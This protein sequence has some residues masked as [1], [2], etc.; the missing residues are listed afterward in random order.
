[1]I[2]DIQSQIFQKFTSGESVLSISKQLNLPY[3]KVDLLLVENGYKKINHCKIGNEKVDRVIS[4]INQKDSITEIAN[5]TNLDTST[6]FYIA[7]ENNLMIEKM[8]P[9]RSPSNWG[10]NDNYFEDINSEEKAYFVGL[11]YA[12]GAVRIHDG[13]YYLSLELTREDAYM[14][15]SLANELNCNNKIAIRNRVTPFGYNSFARFESCNSKKLLDDLSL[16]G[17]IPNKSHNSES[18][19]NIRERIPKHLIRHFLRGLIDGDGS[20][21]KRYQCNNQ[22]SIVIYQNSKKFC[23]D[24]DSLLKFSIGDCSIKES[25]MMNNETGM[26][27][28]RYRRI[29]DVQKIAEHLYKNSKMHLKRKYELAKLYFR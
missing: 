5:K 17:I 26:F 29:G 20:I 3:R 12:D 22:N 2:D 23:D 11:I 8:P 24:F 10:F 1:M 21:S 27:H 13:R 14:V 6:I 19:S 28:L 16:F 15:E 25:L 9:L 4:L 18:F 7:K